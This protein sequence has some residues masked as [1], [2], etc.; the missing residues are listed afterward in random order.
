MGIL[1][2]RFDVFASGFWLTL[3]LC[4]LSGLG[5]LLIGTVVA[6]MRV[7]PLAPLRAAGTAYVTV[8]RNIPLTVVFFF[9][10]FGLPQ[11]GSN[12]D[13]LDVPGLDLVFT[14]LGLDLPYFRFA[15]LALSLYTGAFVCEALRSGV[16]AVPSGQ[17]EAARSLGMTFAQNLRFVILPQAWGYA[18]VPVGSVIIA[19]LKNSA[20]AGFFGVTGDLSSSADTLTFAGGPAD[21][22][23]LHRHLDRLPAAH[24][25]AG[26]P[27]GPGRA[28]PG[29]GLMNRRPTDVLY[30]VAGPRGRRISL[31]VAAAVTLVL[32]AGLYLLV[33]RPLEQHGQFAATKWSAIVDPAD[34]NFP[35]L[36]RRFGLG[37]RNTA[38]AAGLAVASSLVAGTGL[39]VLRLWLQSLRRHQFSGLGPAGA[40]LAR[41]ASWLLNGLTRFFIEVFRGLPVVITIFFV[42]RGLPEFG[43][44]L[45][46]LWYLVI[47]LTI[48][49]GVVVAEILRSGM[50]GLPRGQREAAAAIGLSERQII[51][52]VLLPQ[53]FRIMLPALISQMVVVLKDTSL[54]GVVVGYEELLK[55]GTL[56]TLVLDNPIQIYAVVAVIFLCLNY[57][58]SRLATYVQR[59]SA[60]ISARPLTWPRATQL[61]LPEGRRQEGQ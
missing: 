23:R 10:A 19:M 42:A 54:G 43:A 44:D 60:R 48:Y 59:R 2:D 17:A 55:V 15:I 52:L 50:S 26:S 34:P 7:S 57:A 22:P 20:L 28:T 21:H 8:F 39:G 13:I 56:A 46:T 6:I 16:N 29:G 14:R 1:V 38:V 51:Q 18:I 47:G 11:L 4:L 24:G 12:A 45:P 3:Q 9:T 53:A 32:I 61:L 25:T 35:L 58:L 33:Y 40:Q 36:W 37:L 5:A 31:A 27:A 41:S 49:N 30:D